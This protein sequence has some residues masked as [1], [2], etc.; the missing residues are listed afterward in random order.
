MTSQFAKMIIKLLCFD[1]LQF[2]SCFVSLVNVSY[3]SKFHVNIIPGSGVIV[4]YF[5]S[6]NE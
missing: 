5:Y 1:V 4:I 2:L 3:W 6:F